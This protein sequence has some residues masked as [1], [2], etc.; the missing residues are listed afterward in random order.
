[1]ATWAFY[2]GDRL[3]DARRSLAHSPPTL[4]QARHRFHWKHRRLFLPLGIAAA[5][6]GLAVVVDCMPHS[7]GPRNTL[8]TAAALGYFGSVH[9]PSRFPLPR[10]RRALRLPKELLVG[11]IFAAACALPAWSRM[12]S[13][14]LTFLPVFCVFAA[15]AWL[16]C[17]A[18]EIWETSPYP[19]RAPFRITP[20]AILLA[21]ATLLL[22][23]TAYLLAQPRIAA[24]LATAS[25]SALA[26]AFLDRRQLRL[27]SITLR[28]AA[29][30]VLLT[31]LFL[32]LIP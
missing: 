15:L 11:L 22:A 27:D 3:L 21:V 6:I 14:R 30:L 31:P 23:L 28:A 18:I 1:M 4:L 7:A 26:T 5:L 17:H 19:T 16:N 32:F 8:L 10:L 13:H 24:L 20:M 9:A 29:D 12:P 25:L 2:I